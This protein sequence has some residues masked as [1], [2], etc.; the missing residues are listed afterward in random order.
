[1]DWYISEGPQRKSAGTSDTTISQPLKANAFYQ[2]S[3]E[4]TRHRIHE[5]FHFYEISTLL[6]GGRIAETMKYFCNAIISIMMGLF[7]TYG[8]YMIYAT[9]RK[10]TRKELIG[11]CEVKLNYT[12]INVSKTGSHSVYSP[13]SDSSYGGSSGGGFSGG[14]SSGGSSGGGFSGSGGSH[15]F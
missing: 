15:G 8:F 11:E 4:L 3:K 2:C 10:A 13:V 6:E 14:G 12:P 9:N 7:S 1:M 5:R